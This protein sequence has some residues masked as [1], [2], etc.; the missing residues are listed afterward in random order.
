MP[1]PIKTESN[2]AVVFDKYFLGMSDR[3]AGVQG[4]SIGVLDNGTWCY[5]PTAKAIESKEIGIKILEGIAKS[6]I[7]DFSAW[8]DHQNSGEEED[9]PRE[10]IPLPS[11]SL[12]YAD[13]RTPVTKIGDIYAYYPPDSPM[14]ETALQ[15]FRFAEVDRKEA[16]AKKAT[17]VY[18]FTDEEVEEAFA[19]KATAKRGTRRTVKKG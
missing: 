6:V 16:A 10:I 3:E 17:S 18:G 11:G 9:A 1:H 19:P 4:G 7:P 8:W 2:G 14:L 15:L 12:V 5:F 13:D